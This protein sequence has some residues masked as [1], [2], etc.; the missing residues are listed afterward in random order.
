MNFLRNIVLAGIL[1]VLLSGGVMADYTVTG[2]FKYEDLQQ[3]RNSGFTGTTQN[4]PVRFADVLVMSGST[5]L[6][7]GATDEN[8]FFSISVSASASQ[9]IQVLVTTNTARTATLNIRGI[10]S[11]GGNGTGSIHAFQMYTENGH[12]PNTNIS[13]GEVV[14]GYRQ[15]GEVFNLF[16]VAVDGCLYLIN[17]FGENT[18]PGSPSILIYEHTVNPN[19]A[20]FAYYNGTSVNMG[21]RYGYDDTIMLHEMGHWVQDRFGD[22][23]DNI[24]GQHFIGDALQDPR[25][26]FGEA[27]PTFWAAGVRVYY[28][29]QTGDLLA[30][31]HPSAYINTN[32][33]IDGGLGFSYDLENPGG[34]EGDGGSANE[35][36]VQALLWD[37]VDDA[38]TPDFTPGVDDDIDAGY[39]MARDR[40][41]LWNFTKSYLSQPPFI[42]WLTY[43][44]FRDLWI[45]NISP[46]QASE[47]Q[48]I[49]Y[50]EHR[51]H[52]FPDDLEPNNSQGSATVLDNSNLRSRMRITNYP[53]GDQD[54]FVLQGIAGVSYRFSTQRIRDGADTFM[55]LYNASGSE[56]AS[57]DNAAAPGS[58][59]NR[60]N[61][62]SEVDWTAPTDMP[63]YV[64]ITRSIFNTNDGGGGISK[65]GNYDFQWTITGVPAEFAAINISPGNVVVA[66]QDGNPVDRT[67]NL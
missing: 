64:Q 19:G 16:D 40:L 21:D 30:Y 62:R 31:N 47:L 45:A 28:L 14:A 6:A 9:N 53:E 49:E 12:D 41:E 2:T 65:Y 35:V 46:N 57:N 52:F 32:G 22:F 50:L 23:S 33:S 61:L 34:S 66:S 51:V 44:D 18:P 56:I 42:G 58:P 5:T 1:L 39:G 38:D 20:D 3:H 24:G 27:W 43:E 60:E 59:P 37:L 11:S 36:A 29:Q 26:S 13:I 48:A 8:G 7:Q 17:V 55:R 10:T 54:W 67:V 25:L 4:R 63:V 15:G